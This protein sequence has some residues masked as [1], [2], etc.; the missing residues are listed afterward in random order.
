[1]FM[2]YE[3]EAHRAHF[4][5]LQRHQDKVARSFGTYDPRILR[6]QPGFIKF[7]VLLVAIRDPEQSV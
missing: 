1:M 6:K 3:K 7:R 4:R 5:L 2:A